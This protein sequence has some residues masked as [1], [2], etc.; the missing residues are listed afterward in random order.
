MKASGQRHGSLSAAPFHQPEL[1]THGK[2]YE[3]RKFPAGRQNTSN[4]CKI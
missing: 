4:V 2:E 3:D 1:V